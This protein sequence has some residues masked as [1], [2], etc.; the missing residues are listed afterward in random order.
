MP[1]LDADLKLRTKSR[2]THDLSD[3]ENERAI[4]M[5][6]S[7]IHTKKLEG[8]LP[9]CGAETGLRDARRVVGDGRQ[10]ATVGAI[11]S[12]RNGA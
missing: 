5:L 3:R 4:R 6:M 10:N 11:A 1:W 7:V 12:L 8:L 2:N 9:L